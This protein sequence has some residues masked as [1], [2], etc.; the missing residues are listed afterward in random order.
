ML[1]ALRVSLLVIRRYDGNGKALK[2]A[3]FMHVGALLADDFYKSVY[4]ARVIDRR[5]VNVSRALKLKS[6][7]PLEQTP[8]GL[9][10][11]T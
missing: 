10:K 9:L 3:S 6:P 1:A 2:Y 5:M 7:I 4:L 11:A 8:A